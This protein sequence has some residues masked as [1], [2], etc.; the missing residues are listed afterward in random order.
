MAGRFGN[1]L[2]WD[3]MGWTQIPFGMDGIDPA[4]LPLHMGEGS[5]RTGSI[6]AGYTLLLWKRREGRTA[7]QRWLGHSEKG[8]RIYCY[9]SE[10]A[11]HHG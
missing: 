7:I 6:L 10:L 3:G 4:L 2:G 8:V 5:W 11:S 9:F 1:R